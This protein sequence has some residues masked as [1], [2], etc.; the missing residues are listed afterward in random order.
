MKRKYLLSMYDEHERH[1]D[2]SGYCYWSKPA[3]RSNS[4]FYLDQEDLLIDSLA[5]FIEEH[6]KGDYDIYIIESL[7]W[8]EEDEIEELKSKAIKISKEIAEKNRLKE[9]EEK[10]KKRAAE[11]ERDRQRE[12]EQ[13]AKLKMKYE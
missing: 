10:K 6:P 4:E 5:S 12:L 3:F 2:T 9:I 1:T 7:D 13:L 11:E 8:T